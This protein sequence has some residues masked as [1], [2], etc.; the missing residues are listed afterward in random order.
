ELEYDPEIEKTAKR[1]RKKARKRNFQKRSS[2]SWLESSE[3]NF[4][5]DLFDQFTISGKTCVI[6]QFNGETLYEYWERLTIANERGRRVSGPPQ[7]KLESQASSKLPS[8]TVNNPK[9]NVSAIT[10]RSG[11]VLEEQPLKPSK[12]DLEKEIVKEGSVSQT[13]QPPEMSRSQEEIRIL[14]SFPGHFAKSIIQ[15]Q[16]KEIP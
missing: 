15:E 3:S 9:K 2:S 4:I 5:S 10:L 11:K 1:L 13:V 16:E 14:P 12:R 8:E 6:R 7:R